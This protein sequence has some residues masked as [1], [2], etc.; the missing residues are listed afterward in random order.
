MLPVISALSFIFI[1]L[2]TQNKTDNKRSLLVFLIQCT[3]H[4]CMDVL[5]ILL[6]IIIIIIITGWLLCNT[7][8]K[9]SLHFKAHPF[10]IEFIIDT[11]SIKENVTSKTNHSLECWEVA[12]WLSVPWI[13]WKTQSLTFKFY[14]IKIQNQRG[15]GWAR[16]VMEFD[17]KRHLCV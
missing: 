1:Y 16:S 4:R 14:Q 13:N 8:E 7:K 5:I 17:F 3:P 15:K 10:I 9:C 6:A 12:V 11:V 2:H